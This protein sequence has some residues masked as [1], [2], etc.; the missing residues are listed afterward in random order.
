MAIFLFYTCHSNIYRW[1][2]HNSPHSPS[3]ALFLNIVVAKRRIEI[4]LEIVENYN[5][6]HWKWRKNVSYCRIYISGFLASDFCCGFFSV[7]KCVSSFKKSVRVQSEV[8]EQLITRRW[9]KFKRFFKKIDEPKK[10]NGCGFL[11]K[12]RHTTCCGAVLWF[13]SCFLH[14]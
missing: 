13:W 1:L 11:S 7:W 9:C 4:D 12:L 5:V 10:F 8:L 14:W 6:T 3:F 2:W